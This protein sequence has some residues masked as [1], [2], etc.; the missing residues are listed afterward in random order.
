[1]LKLIEQYELVN[2]DRTQHDKLGTPETFDGHLPIPFEYI[3]EQPVERL[4]RLMAEFM[5][6]TTHFN[7]RFTLARS[8][9]ENTVGLP[10]AR[11][12]IGGVEM[13]ITHDETRIKGQAI[14]VT[15]GDGVVMHIGWRQFSRQRNPDGSKL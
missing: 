3:F 10:T 13:T 5:Q 7:T 15:S 2:D 6:D 8:R 4:N 11:L 9:N 12:Q 14:D 1:M